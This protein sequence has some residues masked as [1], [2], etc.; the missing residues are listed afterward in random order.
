MGRRTT[1][2]EDVAKLPWP[3]GVV[4]AVVIFV[5]MQVIQATESSNH[6]IEAIKPAVKIPAYIFIALF[7]FSSLISLIGQMRKRSKY[8]ATRSASDI[9]SLTWRQFESW[10]GEHFR[11]QG[12][13]V[14][15]TPEGPDNGIDLVLRKDGEKTYVQC[16]HWKANQIGVEKVREL[17]GS[18]AAGGAQ[19]G[20]FV[21]SGTYTEPARKLARESG[22]RLI[23]GA[24]LARLIEPSAMGQGDQQFA[25][26]MVEP[27]NCPSC[28]APMVKRI[29]KQGAN[30]GNAFWG[31]PG[32]PKCRGTRNI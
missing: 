23:D 18:I 8:V 24:E 29:A 31:C 26:T 13:S 15:E 17:L 22:I 30:K 27:P 6:M 10:V 32:Y 1:V 28:D 16:K 7:L 20:V 19:N 11:E 5:G 4:V 2:F 25:S 14:V 9:R 12:Y 3:V 21:A